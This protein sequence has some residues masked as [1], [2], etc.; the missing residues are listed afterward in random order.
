MTEPNGL[1]PF[2]PVFSSKVPNAAKNGE[3]V[4]FFVESTKNGSER[5]TVV[6]RV[7]EDFV[8][9]LHCLKTQDNVTSIIFP[10][11]PAQPTTSLQAA[12]KKTKKQAGEKAKILVGDNY[13]EHCRAYEKFL[14]LCTQHPR[15]GHSNVLQAFAF[16][17]DPPAKV[18]VKRNFFEAVTKAVDDIR[19]ANYKDND[20]SFQQIRVNNN[21]NLKNMK[22]ASNRFQQ[23]VNSEH[24]IS[25][26]Y[27]DIHDGVKALAASDENTMKTDS[28]F[29]LFG[30]ALEHS[31][32]E[33]NV[34]AINRQRSLGAVLQ[35]YSGFAK[36]E[37]EMLQK[38]VQKMV[39]LEN[40]KK[41]FEKAKPQ[42][43]QQAEETMKRLE[44]EL[45]D[46]TELAKP[47][48]E[49]HNRQRLLTMQSALVQLADSEIKNA[50]DG[51]AVFTKLYS[52]VQKVQL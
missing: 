17:K 8:W 20:E 41:T 29:Q 31:S 38:R 12:E 46:M 11:L 16:E 32:E 3:N 33:S 34:I 30:S 5:A 27:R 14:D 36:S 28:L 49:R 22:E 48:L 40:A 23:I 6:I 4:E 24:R 37:H 50:R 47:E 39:E 19:L 43:K 15:L 42:K 9:L 21:E 2:K 13:D 51:L 18:K 45:N 1:S 25:N 26:L 52:D 7:H 35:L 44:R 10:P